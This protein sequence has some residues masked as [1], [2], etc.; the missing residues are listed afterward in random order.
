M[1][2]SEFRCLDLGCS[3]ELFFDGLTGR[4]EFGG[5]R[6]PHEKPLNDRS[7]FYFAC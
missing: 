4:R 5:G 1:G 3:P 6:A 2:A 7:G